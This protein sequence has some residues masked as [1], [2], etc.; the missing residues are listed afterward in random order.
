MIPLETDIE[1]IGHS[2]KRKEDQNF[3]FRSFLKGKD[4][5]KVD[6]IV[7]GINKEI[8]DQI[9]CTLCGNCCKVLRPSVKN[10]EI[11]TLAKIDQISPELFIDKYTEK[12]EFGNTLFLKDTPC[13]YLTDKKCSVYDSRP[14]DCRSFP[15]IHKK[16]FNSR[17]LSMIEFY[18]ICPIV[19]NA[20]ERLKIEVGFR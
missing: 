4:S 7:H 3:R 15:H 5:H 9:D 20:M 1:R 6:R 12:E 8:E 19:F 13:K 11:E 18:R 2:G 14:E 10:K 16:S 17:T